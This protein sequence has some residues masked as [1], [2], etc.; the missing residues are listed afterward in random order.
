MAA[1]KNAKRVTR[2]SKNGK[3]RSTKAKVGK[4]PARSNGKKAKPE[5]VTYQDVQAGVP[6]SARRWLVESIEHSR[7]TIDRAIGACMWVEDSACGDFETEIEA[8]KK[9]G[10]S[11]LVIAAA[12]QAQEAL[13]ELYDVATLPCN[14]SWDFKPV[15]E[16][17][18]V[19]KKG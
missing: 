17:L 1:T 4:A 9:Q 19:L 12:E 10:E 5:P 16:A 18:A 15:D 8:L 13:R 7:E 2:A 11:P 6:G 14:E 3:A